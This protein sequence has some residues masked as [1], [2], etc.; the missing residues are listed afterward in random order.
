MPVFC[1]ISAGD[2]LVMAKTV[3]LCK[4]YNIKVGAHPG[5][6][7]VQGFGRRP[8]TLSLQEH[9]ANVIYQIGA[10]KAF[11]DREG[12]ELHHVKP[13]GALYGSMIRDLDIARAVWAAVPKGVSVIGLAGTH[14]ET[15]AEEAGL[16][17]WAEYFGDVKYNDDGT[18]I[19]DREKKPWEP[20]E[21]KAHVHQ[22]IY[23]SQV[24]SVTGK[25]IDIPIKDYPITLCC[26]SDSPGCIEIVKA[27]REVVDEYN[28]SQGF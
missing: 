2:P 19:I 25:V 23:D 5:L 24:T 4:E 28:R 16:K 26:H 27:S 17:F 7:D 11:L 20:D 8:M 9:T 22:Q 13:H 1:V 15:A 18:L 14:M 21:V 6:P 10:L 12:V 3:A